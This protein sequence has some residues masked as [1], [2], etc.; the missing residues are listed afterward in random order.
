MSDITNLNSL[1]AAITSRLRGAGA[2]IA[3]EGHSTAGKTCLSKSLARACG[4]DSIS[5]DSY[6]DKVRNTDTYLGR[7][8]LNKLAVALS[9]SRGKHPV[10]FIEGICLRDTL[11]SLNIAPQAFVYCK[12]ITQAGL[13]AD[14]PQNYLDGESPRSDLSWVDQQSVLY[15]LRA[16]PLENADIVYARHEE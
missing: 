7:I 13:W 16:S 14:D 10:V 11:A 4:G 12:R 6:V 9:Q 3:I 15:H 8:V 2:L 5:T 1:V